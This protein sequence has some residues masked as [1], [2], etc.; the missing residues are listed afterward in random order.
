MKIDRPGWI[1]SQTASGETMEA[2][3]QS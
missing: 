1:E 2:V 3:T